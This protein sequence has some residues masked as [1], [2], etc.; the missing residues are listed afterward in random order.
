[1]SQPRALLV[2]PI[3]CR[4][5]KSF[6]LSTMPSTSKSSAWTSSAIWLAYSR[7]VS[8]SRTDLTFGVMGM[9][10][11]RIACR[12][13]MWLWNSTPRRYPLPCAKNRTLAGR[14]SL[15][16]EQLEPPAAVFRGLA[17]AFCPFLLLGHE[18]GEIGVGD[19]GFAADFHHG[20]GV[21]VCS[22]RGRPRIVRALLV[23]SSPRVPSPASPPAPAT[24]F[25]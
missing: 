13:S 15:R 12:N 1:M 24:P 8:M 19:V 23:I 9:P 5:S 25:S 17:N 20:G 4:W 22:R 2:R 18:R 10:H 11:S 16:I 6:T 21:L 7:A 14:E 3:R